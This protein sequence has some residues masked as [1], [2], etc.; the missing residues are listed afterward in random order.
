THCVCSSR[1]QPPVLRA[2]AS[3][4]LTLASF[5]AMDKWLSTMRADTSGATL[6]QRVVADKPAE[7]FDFCYLSTDA[8]FS[9]KIQDQA[10]CDADPLL[11]PHSSP[12]QVAGGPVAEN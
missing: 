11:V 2:S 6:E 10:L 3:S 4:G 5:L 8:T 1:V 12:R 9:T 7:G